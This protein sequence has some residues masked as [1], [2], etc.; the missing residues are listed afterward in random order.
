M[1]IA[2][3]T[4]HRALTA[5]A[6]VGA[7]LAGVSRTT[8]RSV[9]RS[10]VFAPVPLGG[11]VG[12][13]V[14]ACAAMTPSLLPRTAATWGASLG[15]AQVFGYT[16][17]TL[18]ELAVRGGAHALGRPLP[19]SPVLPR[20]RRAITTGL[21]LLQ[22]GAALRGL[23]QQHRLSA[24][25]GS[26][27][28][29][30]QAAL[31]GSL[32]GTAGASATIVVVRSVV[33]T[34]QLYRSLLR[35]WLPTRTLGAASLLLTAATVLAVQRAL[36]A[37]LVEHAVQAAETANQLFTPEIERPTDP[38]RSGSPASMLSWSSLGN[39]GRRIVAGGLDTATITA[40]I[41]HPAVAPIRVYAGRRAGGSLD[42]AVAAVLGELD[43]TGAWER[44]VLALFTGTGT[45]WLQ[46]WSLSAIEALTAGDCATASLQYSVLPSGLAAV[47]D[48]RSPQEA[49]QALYRAVRSRLD[50]L[51]VASRPRLVL[52][53]ESLGA[54][55][56]LAAF[57]TPQEL[58][59][60]AD[61]AVWTGAP[62]FT[63]MWR[64]L[65][66]G[67]AHGSLA[68]APVIDGGRHLRVVTRS[69]DLRTAPS[70]APYAPWQA[71]RVV[72][73]QHASDPVAR[74][75]PSLL[76]RRP[77]WLAEKRGHDVS[78]A[79]R[80]FPWITFWQISADM[81]LSATAPTGH[82]H[83]YREEMVEIW[84]HVLA[85]ALGKD[86]LAA[87]TACDSALQARI[88]A[89]IRAGSRLPTP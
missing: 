83:S 82:G 35:P 40:T 81:P 71:P 29:S 8:R 13:A 28:L 25:V 1:S 80:W 4:A 84:A 53:G 33:A 48:R 18:G 3:R 88:I 87:R 68:I 79:V 65:A 58:L 27:P 6:G 61:G 86:S 59:A 37:R 56:G 55:G 85:G 14:A 9:R 77:R 19:P 69:A 89:A 41:E 57:T 47:I 64:R 78:P 38:L 73:A 44:S 54:F 11:Q 72:F 2:A 49:G 17:G 52:A 45:G 15:F 51:P 24:L 12:A 39:Q 70:G 7:V 62:G 36:R 21:L 60:G 66:A 63:P 42:D 76:W 31:R 5:A 67:A 23:Q 30:P 10:A 50:A 46:E 74:W 20:G 34:G 26:R 43:R 32:G 16:A 22:A 75:E